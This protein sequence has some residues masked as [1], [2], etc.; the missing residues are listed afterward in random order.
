MGR[1]TADSQLWLAAHSLLL[2]R[3]D[4]LFSLLTGV[5]EQFDPEAIHD[6]RVA[7]RRL[8]EALAL[9][10]PAYPPHHLAPLKRTLKKLTTM[11]GAIRNSDEA[12]LFFAGLTTSVPAA[13]AAIAGITAALAGRREAERAA[14]AGGLHQLDVPRLRRRLTTMCDRL[15]LFGRGDDLL[16]PFAPFLLAGL[17]ARQRD[18]DALLGPAA[19]EADIGAQHRLRIAVKH[20][21]YRFELLAPFAAA[22]YAELYR[23]I[24]GYQELLGQMHDLDTFAL[25]A[26]AEIADQAAAALVT[27]PI[28]RQRRERFARFSAMQRSVPLDTLVAR[29]RRLV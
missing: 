7:S 2:E 14:L 22:D 17:D 29:A 23:A 13:A 15:Q 19:S 9:F 26:T 27:A 25:L 20:F 8:R 21:R 11:M 3:G 24:K 16:Q 5:Q 10:A 4:E 18:I 28:A 1:V 6:L 12:L